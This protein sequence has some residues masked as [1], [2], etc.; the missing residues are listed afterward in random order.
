VKHLALRVL[1]VVCIFG[2]TAFAQNLRPI[3]VIII[4]VPSNGV[5]AYARSTLGDD[6]TAACNKL[7]KF[8]TSKSVEIVKLCDLETT[9]SG[10]V[11]ASLNKYFGG[12]QRGQLNLVFVMAHG[13][14]TGNK[15]VRL[16]LSDATDQRTIIP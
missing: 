13:E 9:K 5:S 6:I 10:F 15:D 14:A 1:T 16:L 7:E 12:Q 3:K 8:F 4:G 2:V 11:H